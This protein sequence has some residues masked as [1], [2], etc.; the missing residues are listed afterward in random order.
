LYSIVDDGDEINI[1][2]V[3]TQRW[4][5]AE[6][7]LKLQQR[8]DGLPVNL[9]TTILRAEGLG[10]ADYLAN[11]RDV[12]RKHVLY[13]TGDADAPDVIKDR[14]GE[15]VLGLCRVCGRGE[16]ELEHPCTPR[17]H[18]VHVTG[19]A[20][21]KPSKGAIALTGPAATDVLAAVDAVKAAFEYD[22][23]DV[24]PAND[25]INRKELSDE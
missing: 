13:K 15:V 11:N 21:V 16:I 6:L 5:L 14:N 1:R 23:Q 4:E 7:V 10:A 24:Q 19:V 2:A 18:H 3:I 25:N 20:Y 12:N 22:A 8:V 17:E 9:T